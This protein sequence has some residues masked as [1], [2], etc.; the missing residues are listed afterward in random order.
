MRRQVT[1]VLVTLALLTA[2]GDDDGDAD[3]NAGGST[4]GTGGEAALPAE[5]P[6]TGAID[7]TPRR[8]DG[9]HY[10]A[11]APETDTLRQPGLEGTPLVIHGYVLF[12]DCRTVPDAVLDVWQADVE[13]GFDDSGWRLRGVFRADDA[14]RYRIETILP[15]SVDGD[16]PTVHIKAAE[17][18]GGRIVTTQI[19]LAA[20]EAAPRAELAVDPTESGDGLAAR[21]DLVIEV[22]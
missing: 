4:A 20:P 7:V 8:S 18:I 17:E 14:G 19:Y 11:G 10:R 16:P 6:C 22:G 9:G 12:P 3:N 5:S 13:G 21:F 15:G 2:C 1:V